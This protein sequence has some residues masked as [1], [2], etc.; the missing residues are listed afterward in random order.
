MQPGA[1]VYRASGEPASVKRWVA[2]SQDAV[3]TEISLGSPNALLRSAAS[4]ILV[5]LLHA[6]GHCLKMR[7]CAPSLVV[8]CPVSAWDPGH[9]PTG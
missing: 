3:L 8:Q 1:E 4:S 6:V 9:R 5:R 7:V 2:A